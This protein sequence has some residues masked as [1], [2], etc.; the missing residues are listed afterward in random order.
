LPV[1]QIDKILDWKEKELP[2]LL[3][4]LACEIPTAAVLAA[5]GRVDSLL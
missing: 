1:E 2:A 3:K 4:R 5:L